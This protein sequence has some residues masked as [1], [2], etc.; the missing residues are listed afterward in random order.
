MQ[1]ASAIAALLQRAPL[2]EDFK[3][4]SSRVGAAGGIALA[5]GLS[6]GTA[7][8]ASAR[9][10]G[11]SARY[12]VRKKFGTRKLATRRHSFGFQYQPT[13]R[14]SA[15]SELRASQGQ[16]Q[17]MVLNLSFQENTVCSPKPANTAG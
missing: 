10:F 12:P 3:M 14:T 13:P 6:T 7:T 2:V 11:G 15:L 8:V 17:E 16:Q 5:Q 9:T 4:V 1:G